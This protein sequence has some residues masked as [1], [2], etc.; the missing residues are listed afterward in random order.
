M[1]D[2]YTDYLVSRYE[3][4]PSDSPTGVCVGFTAKCNPNGRSNYWDTLVASSSTAG[5]TET[6]IVG[7]AWDALSGSMVPWGETEMHESA[8]IGTTYKVVSGSA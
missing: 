2:C 5:K 1:A 3:W 8:L 4:Y 6:E 7:L